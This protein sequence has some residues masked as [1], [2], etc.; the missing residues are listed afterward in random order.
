MY[1][2]CVHVPVFDTRCVEEDAGASLGRYRDVEFR[3][4]DLAAAFDIVQER[5]YSND[6]VQAISQLD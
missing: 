4:V 1:N 5:V 6:T 2:L 3:E